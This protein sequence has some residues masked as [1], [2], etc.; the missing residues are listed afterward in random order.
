MEGRFLFG[1]YFVGRADA[2]RVSSKCV[3]SV[4]I[5]RSRVCLSPE[6]IFQR[7][8]GWGGNRRH[9]PKFVSPLK[10]QES[11]KALAFSRQAMAKKNNLF[12]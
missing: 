10:K 6:Y 9:E 3:S 1:F 12:G 11:V 2:L 7:F 4:S 8:N 5:V